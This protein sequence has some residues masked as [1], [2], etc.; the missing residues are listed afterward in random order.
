MMKKTKVM[1]EGYVIEV[2]PP[3]NGF[4]DDRYMAGSGWRASAT[5]LNEARV[6]PS[7][8]KLKHSVRYMHVSPYRIVKVKLTPIAVVDDNGKE[9]KI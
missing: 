4:E 5:S 9:T 7:I 8:S 2:Q 3:N 1:D 6:F